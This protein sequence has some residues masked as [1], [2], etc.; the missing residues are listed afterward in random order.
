[1]T[2]LPASTPT[3]P[4]A[5][6]HAVL[7]ALRRIARGLDL[8]SRYLSQHYGLTGPQLL[9][10][11][12]LTGGDNGTV[13]RLA[14][15]ISVSQA[16]LTG[17]ID[18]LERKGLVRRRRDQADKRRVV[19]EVTGTGRRALQ[20]P[21]SLLQDSFVEKFTRLEAEEQ[22]QILASLER[23]LAMMEPERASISDPAETLE[24]RTKA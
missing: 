6:C 1:M 18:R 13:G 24:A 16:T 10:L 12:E 2:E 11:R 9:L 15:A 5:A 7:V 3:N 4:D 21:P 19:V 20:S 14:E 23:L 22:A 8:H 17:I